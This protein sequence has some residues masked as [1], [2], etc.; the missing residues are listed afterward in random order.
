MPR[1]FL[2][3]FYLSFSV[4]SFFTFKTK[5]TYVLYYFEKLDSKFYFETPKCIMTEQTGSSSSL[6]NSFKRVKPKA[7][8]DALA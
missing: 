3:I 4:I 5:F 8:T 6:K 1:G 2:S 7:G